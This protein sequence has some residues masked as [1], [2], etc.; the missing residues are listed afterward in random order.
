MP[1]SPE[2]DRAP[3]RADDAQVE[4]VFGGGAISPPL[5]PAPSIGAEWR[6]LAGFV[7]RP[8]LPMQTGADR[9]LTI[10]ARIYALDIAVMFALTALAGLVMALG[11]ELPETALADVEFTPAIVLLVIVG[12]PVFEELAFRGWLS[13][14]PGHVLAAAIVAVGLFVVFATD[15]TSSDADLNLVAIGLAIAIFVSTL[16]SLIVL[17]GRAPMGWFARFFP[18][19]FWLSTIGFALVH[20]ANFGDAPLVM[21]LPLVLPQFV[22]GA[23]LGY[24]RVT[25]GLWA[26]ILLH[27]AHNATALVIATLAMEAGGAA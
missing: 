23:M 10:I 12:A 25:V 8:V 16:A 15:L 21:V 2:H 18:V 7:K 17:R 24:L 27:A 22:L 6:R 19:F 9:P 3:G 1:T 26:A 14:R 13:G 20:V 5:A 4:A 11:I